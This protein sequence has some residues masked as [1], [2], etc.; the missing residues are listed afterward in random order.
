ME[1]QVNQAPQVENVINTQHAEENNSH[2]VAQ[3]GGKKLTYIIK[4]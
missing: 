1:N 2:N 4:Q 3:N